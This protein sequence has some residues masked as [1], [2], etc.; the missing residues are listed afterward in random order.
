MPDLEILKA[1]NYRPTD[2][3]CIHACQLYDKN[4]EYLPG[5]EQEKMLK[6]ARQWLFVWGHVFPDLKK[7]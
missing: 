7:Y 5:I 6:D 1:K 2:D 3:E 4:W